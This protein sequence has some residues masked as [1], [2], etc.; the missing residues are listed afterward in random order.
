MYGKA[1]K[2]TISFNVLHSEDKPSLYLQLI[3]SPCLS[4]CSHCSHYIHVCQ[5]CSQ[6]FPLSPRPHLP[7]TG[8][9]RHHFCSNERPIRGFHHFLVS[10]TG[11]INTN[12]SLDH[13]IDYLPHRPSATST[14]ALLSCLFTKSSQDNNLICVT[15][16]TFTLKL[17]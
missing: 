1:P 11:T 12:D 13:H 17:L 9:G 3:C 8:A 4:I 10:F 15:H 6:P 2:A 14:A 7:V 5:T 16:T